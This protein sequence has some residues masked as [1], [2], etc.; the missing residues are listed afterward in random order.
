VVAIRAN[1][2]EAAGQ[3]AVAEAVRQAFGGL[4]ILFINAGVADLRPIEQWDE[5]GFDRSIAINLK[6]PF[7]LVQALLPI[8]ANPASIVLNGSANAHI[9]MP[10]TS[11]YSAT[12]AGLLSLL[13]S[14]YVVEGADL[15]VLREACKDVGLEMAIA[16]DGMSAQARHP[17]EILGAYDLVFAKARCALEAL[18]CGC[19]VILYH[20]RELGPMVTSEQI[21]ELR[22]WNLGMRCL[23]GTTDT[24]RCSP[25]DRSL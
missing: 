1:V 17:E 10:N 18:A 16:G 6:G 20:V 23:Q 12:K 25:R 13:F 5:A 11:V 15:N 7:F 9:G 4:D 8:L 14:N 3:R 24:G 2:G 19:A 21:Q 22:R